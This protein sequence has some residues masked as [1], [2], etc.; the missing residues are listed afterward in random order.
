MS[1]IELRSYIQLLM[2]VLIPSWQFFKS[3]A[4][5]PR[6]EFA[7]LKT[8][9]ETTLSWQEFSLCPEKRGLLNS[10]ASIF[11]NRSWNES[12]FI[13]S[14]AEKLIIEDDENS[15]TEII[16]RLRRNLI[17]QNKLKLSDTPYLQFRLVFIS[18]GLQR[19][20]LYVSGVED[21]REKAPA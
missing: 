16:E 15:K 5:S 17:S 7:L 12:L 4:P 11:F 1:R 2:P 18:Q 13:N 19:D 10:L 6:I 3:I 9:H 14:S 20:I 8:G 21:I